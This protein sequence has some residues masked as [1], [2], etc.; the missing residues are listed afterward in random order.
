MTLDLD[1]LTRQLDDQVSDLSATPDLDD[2][3]ARV[4]GIHRR[5]RRVTGGVT[6]ALVLALAAG[7]VVWSTG[8]DTPTKVSVADTAPDASAQLP[9]GPIT[10]ET[11]YGTL[12]V[13]VAAADG[14]CLGGT[15]LTV[16]LVRPDGSEPLFTHAVSWSQS[17]V[18]PAAG[19]HIGMIALS[20]SDDGPSLT[21]I[22]GAQPGRY[23][24]TFA[25]GT[26]DEATS[27]GGTIV[28]VGPSMLASVVGTAEAT[29]APDPTA[30]VPNMTV[31][32]LTADGTVAKSW[33][34]NDLVATMER[35]SVAPSEYPN[36]TCV[37]FDGA[38]GG[39]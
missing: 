26:T 18:D 21:T 23:R 15:T 37:T 27:V 24:A 22:V 14:E 17:R 31:D 16:G 10:R 20:A 12:T 13:E 35:G 11:P 36:G 9:A 39:N 5:R 2:L 29:G 6:A 30:A 34:R 8:D 7:S 32:R 1:D 19:V 25:D 3:H 28:I 33:S 4:G 38:S